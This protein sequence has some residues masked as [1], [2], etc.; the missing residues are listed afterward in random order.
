MFLKKDNIFGNMINQKIF[1]PLFFAIYLLAGSSLVADYGIAFDEDMQ[2]SMGQNRI[3]YIIN[4]LS[5]IFPTINNDYN[6]NIKVEYPEYGALFEVTAL[7]ID[8]MFNFPDTRSQFFLRHYL[9]FFTSFI[10]SIFFYFLSLKRFNSWKIALFGTLLLVS[11]PRIFAASFYNSKDIIFMYFFIINT[12]FAIIFLEKPNYSNA[13]FFA[14]ASA[15]S[16]S[17]RVAGVLVPFLTLFFLFIKFLR[18]DYLLNILKYFLTFLIFF[19]LFAILFWPSLWENP[20]SSFIDSVVSFKSYDHSMFNFYL[21]EWTHSTAVHWYYIPLWISVT[22]PIMIIVFFLYGFLLSLRRIFFRL[23]NINNINNLNDLWR[24]RHEL[25]DLFFFTLLFLPVFFIIIFSS[26]LYSGWRHVYF[27]YPFIILISLYG[28]RIAYNRVSRFKLF[29]A[30]ILFISIISIFIIF[31]IYWLYKG[32]PFQNSYFN[33]L[34]GKEPHNRFQVDTWG[35]SNRFV[36]EKIINE[37]KKNTIYVSAISVTPLGL[38]FDILT[39][40]QKKRVKYADSFENSDYIIN[41]GTFIWGDYRKI[42]KLPRNFEIY[43]ELF[44]GD[45]LVTTIYKRKDLL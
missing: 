24:G 5:K 8:K 20:L 25:Q 17:I 42:K 9:I 39:S 11:S 21:G 7:W 38:N 34:A 28:F 15:L 3:D 37:D 31:N 16:V 1:V 4:F 13:I 22:T 33:L 45:I 2:R 30:K 36:L 29:N 27:L 40:E 18:K 12:F 26:T 32:H 35:L 23:I 19:I 44:I 41:N 43:Y 14:L 10:G 6:Q